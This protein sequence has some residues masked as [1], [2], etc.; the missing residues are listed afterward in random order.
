[1][2]LDYDG[3]LR[4]LEARPETARPGSEVHALLRHLAAQPAI[5][6]HL[7]SG[8]K[9]DDLETWFGS[10]PFALIAEH[11][12]TFLRAGRQ[13]WELL[14]AALDLSWKAAVL[15]TLRHY[16]EITPGSQVEEK[17]ASIAW[18]YRGADPASG[19]EK[20]QQ[21]VSALSEMTHNLPVTVQHGKKIVEVSSVHV[22]KA[23]AMHEFLKQRDYD[24]VICAGD[25]QTDEAMF[26]AEIEP[27]ISIKVGGGETAAQYRVPTPWAFRS[28]LRRLLAA[29][30]QK[31]A[32]EPAGTFPAF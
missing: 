14:D 23:A 8:R 7:I 29:M 27:M 12:Y 25:D 18:H 26:R 20:A 4:E 32:G 6:T 21:L 2:F 10:Y 31:P 17:H 16:E 19:A 28:L 11:G 9:A 1:M 30:P 3:T 5:D 13:D 24:L 22:N 15:E